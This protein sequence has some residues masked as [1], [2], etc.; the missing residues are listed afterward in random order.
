MAT[1]KTVNKEKKVAPKVEIEEIDEIQFPPFRVM[2]WGA[3]EAQLETEL[4]SQNRNISAIVKAGKYKVQNTQVI[5]TERSN[6]VY[7]IYVVT[8][9]RE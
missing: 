4:Y 7:Y 8:L 3:F 2:Q 6:Q 1:T 5:I 9:F